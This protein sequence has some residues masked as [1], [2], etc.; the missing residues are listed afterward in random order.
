M[1]PDLHTML[2]PELAVLF[3]GA[4]PVSELR[5]AIPLGVALG[6]SPAAAFLWAAL[7]NILPVA[8]ILLLLDEVVRRSQRIEW[9]R[10]FF[11]WFYRRTERRSGQVA[12]WGALGLLLF[13]AVPLPMTGAY[14]GCVAASI[15]R[16]P[17]R[18]AFPA[19]TGGVVVAGIIVTALTASVIG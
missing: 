2:G 16:I 4:V 14:S 7:G 19:I 5:G 8:P 12:R 11:A 13:V 10:R 3:A 9:L 6:L 17:F 1:T 18:W 15:F